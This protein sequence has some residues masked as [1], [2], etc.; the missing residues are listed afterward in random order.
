MSLELSVLCVRLKVATYCNLID[1]FS[2]C[3]MKNI[4]QIS[5]IKES[6][7]VTR[8]IISVFINCINICTQKKI[9]LIQYF[10]FY[11]TSNLWNILK[12]NMKSR[13]C[14]CFRS[15]S[16][17]FSELESVQD[18][19]LTNKTTSRATIKTPSFL[20]FDSMILIFGLLFV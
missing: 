11:S 12:L 1:L 18:G 4:S 6:Y 15:G 20:S 2:L 8:Y 5:Q 9:A 19:R 10:K 16:D 14:D 17:H 3:Y 13:V 7:T